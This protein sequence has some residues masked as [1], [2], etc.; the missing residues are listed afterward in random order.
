M[1]PYQE[2]AEAIKT[3]GEA[4]LRLGKSAGNIAAGLGTA[5]Y[6]GSLIS[7]VVPWLSKYIPEDLF[8]KGLSKIDPRFGKFIDKAT[9]S[10]KSVDEIKDFI[11]QKIEGGME[12]NK[13]KEN[14][15]II[16]QESPELHQFIDQEIKNG[17]KPIEAGA[18]A[19]NDKNYTKA[20]NSLKNKHKLNW[21]DIVQQVYGT[22]DKALPNQ[23]QSLAEEAMNPP[24]SAPTSPQSAESQAFS[25]LQSQPQQ[26]QQTGPGQKALMDILQKIDQKLGK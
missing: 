22:G 26:I 18:L 20:I 11:G 3:Q 5:Y 17:R 15:N 10:G 4:P 13:P 21:A 23:Q 25:K 14:R 9:Q 6:G 16:E 19:Y 8:K 7:R 1:Q 24:G 2:A 12:N